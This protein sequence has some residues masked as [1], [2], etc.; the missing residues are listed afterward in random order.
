MFQNCPFFRC[1]LFEIINSQII[2]V[3]NCHLFRFVL[4]NMV[5]WTNVPFQNC[6]FQMFLFQS[7]MF[8][9]CPCPDV[10]FSILF[11]LNFIFL[12]C[13]F[14][15][16]C[17]VK[18]TLSFC[19]IIAFRF[20]HMFYFRSV[21]F[22]VFLV[23]NCPF[24]DASFS[25]LSCFSCVLFRVVLVHTCPF[26]KCPFSDASFSILSFSELALFGFQEVAYGSWDSLC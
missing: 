11:L 16:F 3:Q 19:F 2:L 20:F 13:P 14:V 15:Q 12:N 25:E 8:S 23:L 9:R 1:F 22:Q 4:C 7:S 24:S 17:L 18:L 5:L 6:N 21:L 10:S 26:R